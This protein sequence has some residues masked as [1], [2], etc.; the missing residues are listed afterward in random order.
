VHATGLLL[1]LLTITVAF[2]SVASGQNGFRPAVVSAEAYLLLDPEG[3][4]LSA[5]NAGAERAPA[6]LVKLMTLY[7]ACEAL[8]SGRAHVDEMVQVSRH[9]ATTPRYRMGLRTGEQ[10][11][12]QVLLEGVAIASA[13]DAATALAEHVAGDET[14][15]VEQMNS[16]AREFG[17][18]N[19]RFTNPH[20]L[21][22]RASARRLGNS[23][24]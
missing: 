21:Q 12:M 8:D 16:K 3:R 11:S 6:S 10:V 13:N 9:A 1:L 14:L 17:L 18:S 23:L 24:S 19:T 7:L 5:K 4:T 15:F 20:G 22:T 2:P